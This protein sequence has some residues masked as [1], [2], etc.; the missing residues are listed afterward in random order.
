M[1]DAKR[2]KL[3]NKKKANDKDTNEVEETNESG[4]LTTAMNTTEGEKIEETVPVIVTNDP[5]SISSSE[6]VAAT[7][8]D[9][10]VIPDNVNPDATT[11]TA[12]VTTNPSL[13]MTTGTSKDKR[14]F[15]PR[16]K[17]DVVTMLEEHFGP[18]IYHQ[19]ADP[20][21]PVQIELAKERAE[22]PLYG[23]YDPFIAPE[24]CTDVPNWARPIPLPFD[25]SAVESIYDISVTHGS[26]GR[27]RNR[28]TTRDRS[29]E[30]DRSDSITGDQSI[31]R[32]LRAESYSSIIAGSSPVT[33]PQLGAMRPSNPINLHTNQGISLALPE[34]ESLSLPG[35]TKSGDG[36]ST[37]PTNNITTVDDGTDDLLPD[38]PEAKA[39]ADMLSFR[40]AA[41]ADAEILADYLLDAPVKYI[42]IESLYPRVQRHGDGRESQH[43][44]YEALNLGFAPDAY[45]RT[46]AAFVH[47]SLINEAW[48]KAQ[49]DGTA[50]SLPLTPS[51]IDIDVGSLI[52]RPGYPTRG[53]TTVPSGNAPIFA[54]GLALRLSSWHRGDEQDHPDMERASLLMDMAVS[55]LPY[56]NIKHYQN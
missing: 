36:S 14:K 19:D 42:G 20:T 2:R 25:P 15:G 23:D 11:V 50:A 22:D 4:T 41:T 8:L 27:E 9:T 31:Q 12:T 45:L 47:Q 51:G 18:R 55:Q 35:P 1:D 3:N 30:R 7:S 53:V 29:M 44:F 26:S 32:R 5:A 52:R 40:L 24:N 37:I 54:D 33:S 34:M 56:K 17:R 43:P 48:N 38:C 21:D 39:Y 28:S 46:H 49:M 6:N 16:G 13:P 10:T